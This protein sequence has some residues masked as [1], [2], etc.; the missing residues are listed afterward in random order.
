M[1]SANARRSAS[2]YWRDGVAYVVSAD[3]DVNGIQRDGMWFVR[4]DAPLIAKPLGEAV[5]GALAASRDG[6]PGRL[7]ERGVKQPPSAF[8]QFTGLKSWKALERG[9]SYFL[10]AADQDR[11]RITPSV[12]AP[13]GGF[14]HRRDR[15]VDCAPNAAAV[16]AAIIALATI[17]GPTHAGTSIIPAA[18]AGSSNVSSHHMIEVDPIS[19]V[20]VPGPLPRGALA[21]VEVRPRN[22]QRIFIVL[23][24]TNV[25]DG[26]LM[27]AFGV[28]RSYARRHPEDKSHVDFTLLPDG[29][30]ETAS[31]ARGAEIG[32]HL[33]VAQHTSGKEEMTKELF[34]RATN[35]VPS[36]FPGFGSARVVDWSLAPE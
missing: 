36:N 28:T 7:Y 26:L 11:V 5:L 29:S 8:L 25:N 14:L 19:I 3:R 6:I 22:L 17:A 34:V 23:S 9:A 21:V 15:G 12:A 18:L 1:S 16:G 20:L 30:L 33:P 24:E 27:R 32:S 4:L 2:I 13:K 31:D 35:V 10:V